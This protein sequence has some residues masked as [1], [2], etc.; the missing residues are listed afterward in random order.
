MILKEGRAAEMRQAILLIIVTTA[1]GSL[2]AQTTPISAIQAPE[3]VTPRDTSEIL[4][5]VEVLKNVPYCTGGGLPL[6]MDL[7]LPRHPF[8]KLAPA[9]LWLHGGGWR[10]G[11]KEEGPLTVDFASHGLIVA[12]ANYRLS[13]ESPFPAAI[14]DAKCAVRYLRANATKYGIDPNRMGVAGSS[15]GGHLALLV[16]TAHESAGFEGS[17][18]WNGVNSRVSAVL[19]WFG[20]SDF[21][22]GPEAFEKGSG[23]SIRLFLGGNPNQKSDNYKNASPVNWASNDDPP[24]LLIHGD[25]DDVVP[26]D[27]SVRMAKAYRKFG[28]DVRLVRVKNAG[29]NFQKAGRAPISPSSGKIKAISVAFFERTLGAAA[30]KAADHNLH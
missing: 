21:S 29:H 26:F 1:V 28:L 20:P 19:S 14:E 17:G 7:Y 18:G 8:A 13:S 3:M 15:A 16:A 9:I 10:I 24:L 30:G 6:L 4:K 11:S 22:V 5:N 27:Q 12:S 2:N 23:F 25:K